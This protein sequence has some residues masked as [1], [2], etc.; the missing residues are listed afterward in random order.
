MLWC[1]ISPR[2][3]STASETPIARPPSSALPRSIK[4]NESWAVVGS[5]FGEKSSVFDADA[6]ETPADTSF[7]ATACGS[8]SFTGRR[9]DPHDCVSVVSFADKHTAGGTFHDYTARYRAVRE[10]D[11]ITLRQCMFPETIDDLKLQTR[12][13]LEP[14]S[15][16]HRLFGPRNSPRLEMRSPLSMS[17]PT[18][19][20]SLHR[21]LDPKSA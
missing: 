3:M 11:Q 10:E 14:T 4:S 21:P 1:S 7:A 2:L 16:D 18:L 5:G 19:E 6:H 15:T 13:S 12:I 17:M 8:I 9:V 20:T